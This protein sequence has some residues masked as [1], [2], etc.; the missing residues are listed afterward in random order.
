M[1]RRE[2]IKLSLFCASAVLL[3]IDIKAMSNFKKT[4]ILVEL[5]G[6]NDGLNTVVP[7]T[8][9]N[10]YRLRP[11]IG[12]KKEK[13]NEVEKDFGLNKSLRWVSKLYRE[14]NCAI[15]HGL[16]YDKPNLSHFRSIEIVETASES[17]EYLDEGWISQTL[18]KFDL[19]DIRPANAIL[20]GKRKRGYLFSKDLNVL[21]I[22][23]I[24]QFIK[25]ARFLDES[26][27]NI[28][29]N[30]S[31]DFLKKEEKSIKLASISLEKHVNNINIKTDFEETDISNDF[32]EAV[33]LIKSKIDIPVIKISQK[34]YDTHA[35]QIERQN[36][37][38]KEFDNAIRSFVDE[39]KLENLFNDVLIMTYSEFGRR[40]KENGSN[41]T[42]HGTA[43]CQFV[44][45]GRVRG[46]MYGRPPSLNNLTKNNLI[47]TTH[48]RTYY[49]TILSNW[50]GNKTNQFNSY[51]ILNFL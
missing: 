40:V 42:D 4:L 33:K 20:L 37:L 10:Y 32:K 12:L 50:F 5:D 1:Q 17:N 7:Y 41:G 23:N 15:V 19:N 48:Y 13:I 44:I 22:K 36:K 35:N 34:G 9:K 38:L 11:T 47:Y 2:F 14:D 18:Q 27:S 49:N 3:P 6:G 21:Q 16:G 29:I 31:L 51:D 39:L 25:K 46:G 24:K 26:N 8:D 45:G 30:S 28:G 43:S